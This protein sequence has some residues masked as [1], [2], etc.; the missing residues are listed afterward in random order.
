MTRLLQKAFLVF[1]LSSLC[2]IIF[3]TQMLLSQNRPKPDLQ[4]VVS[5]PRDPSVDS[6]PPRD[7]Q[8]T[9]VEHLK[10]VSAQF[11]QR[12]AEISALQI[13]LGIPPNPS[14][15]RN[16]K[17]GSVGNSNFQRRL[18]DAALYTRGFTE[19]IESK[20]KENY[21]ASN[22]PFTHRIQASYLNSAQNKEPKGDNSP[23]S[24]VIKGSPTSKPNGC[25]ILL[26]VS[27]VTP[28]GNGYTKVVH[29]AELQ[30][31]TVAIKYAMENGM[32]LERCVKLGVLRE[33][34]V[35]LSN[36]KIMK[37]ISLHQQLKH[38]NIIEMFGYCLRKD[39]REMGQKP[40]AI[41]VNGIAAT[42][43]TE[44]GKQLD[45]ITILQ[46]SWEDRL[47]IS[48]GIASLLV[49]M[50]ES[51]LGSLGIHD[52]KLGQ[53]VLVGNQIKLSD[54]DDVDNNEPVCNQEKLCKILTEGA[55]YSIATKCQADI[56]RCIGMNEKL[57]LY[58]SYRYFFSIALRIEAPKALESTIEHFLNKTARVSWGVKEAYRELERITR[59]YVSGAYLR[60]SRQSPTA[61]YK[62]IANADY[63]GQFDYW[64]PY[65]LHAGSNSCTFTVFDEHEAK[66][67]CDSD[68]Y[69]KAFV[70]TE[71][72][73]WT[74][75]HIAFF[76]NSTSEPVYNPS[77]TLYMR[78][79]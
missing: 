61:V 55:K 57:N 36:F 35:N 77:S 10:E 38:P 78:V 71:Q 53:F 64:C 6:I 29:K 30:G 45:I 48:L 5:F 65:T 22:G 14:L 68:T 11:N 54:M 1:C 39:D 58:N 73:S 27:E 67:Y 50:S 21:R 13:N 25:Q 15:Y 32:D 43:I 76:K 4:T 9:L 2:F 59:L 42:I 7:I 56:G 33:D 41:G 26:Q 72:T 44:L 16:T 51:P 60:T 40:Q 28:I 24:V 70:L 34:C 69:C 66:L 46:L 19:H 62:I 3:T 75:R 18:M 63:T 23:A 12:L 49:Y 20:G 8:S 47:R 37:E 17:V 79:G 31:K 74:G 52:F